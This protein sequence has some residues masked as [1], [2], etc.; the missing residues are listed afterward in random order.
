[1]TGKNKWAG[2]WFALPSMLILVLV[3]VAPIIYSGYLS[4]TSYDGFASGE[5]VGL[6][7]YR[8]LLTDQTLHAALWHTLVF[9]LIAVPLQ[10]AIPLVLAELLART[11]VTWL[12]GFVRSVLFIP[13]IA[14]LIL[15]GT[16]WQFMLSS[17]GGLFNTLLGF[18]GIGPVHFLGNPTLALVSVALVTVWKNIGYFLVIYYAA[19]LDIPKHRYEAAMVDGAGPVQR[20]F[21]ITL[22]GVAPVTFLVMVLSTIWSFQV[23]DLVYVMTGG[24]PGGATSTIVMAIYEQAFVKFKMGYSSAIAVVLL[25]IVVVIS[26]LQR[27][28]FAKEERA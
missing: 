17:E 12:S 24:G 14:S 26:A 20:F 21:S 6:R 22:P 16:I 7:N 11:K 25:V 15:V 13:V 8:L 2:L 4:T 9:T 1:M 23:F 3:A 27:L 18:V 19:V 5:V 10:M 28:L